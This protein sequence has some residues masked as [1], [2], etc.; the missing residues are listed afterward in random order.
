VHN[1][2]K[3]ANAKT[4]NITIDQ[5]ELIK[6]SIIDDGSGINESVHDSEGVGIINMKHRTSLLGGSIEWLPGE[7]SGTEVRI[8]L[9]VQ[10]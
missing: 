8:Q 2:I 1:S 3:H 4:I 10:P 5:G 7:N 9:P 6:V